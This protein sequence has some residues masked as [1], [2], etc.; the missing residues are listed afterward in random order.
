M[1]IYNPKRHNLK[2][3]RPP[4][5]K[6]NLIATIISFSIALEM[7]V[8]KCI[9]VLLHLHCAES[10][11]KIWKGLKEE[12]KWEVRGNRD[13]AKRTLV[14]GPTAVFDFEIPTDIWKVEKIVLPVSGAIIIQENHPIVLNTFEEKCGRNFA[15]YMVQQKSYWR[16]WFSAESWETENEPHNVATPSIDRIPC[17]CDSIVIPGD[18]ILPIDLEL[19]DYLTVKEVIINGMNGNFKE[20]LESEL[21][22]L[23][24]E[25]SALTTVAE[26]IC[27][28]THCTCHSNE[29]FLKYMEV[30]CNHDEYYCPT[31]YCF[32][33]IKPIGHCCPICGAMIQLEDS[34][35]SHS[36][37]VFLNKEH[38]LDAIKE[39]IRLYKN[40]K[41]ADLIDMSINIF[42]NNSD[43]STILQI[44]IV[45]RGEYNEYSTEIVKHLYGEHLDEL[46]ILQT[47]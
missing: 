44:T 15:N 42:P 19:I 36:R 45:D 12:G 6:W 24:F 14:F 17:E 25:D 37:S 29:R 33:P 43:V 38:I 5:N 11:T 35:E 31:P 8:L 23:M 40:G 30:V 4:F 3:I 21:G 47:F 34:C 22:Q 2:N 9:F 1:I 18:S 26:S 20:L 39:T 32:N 16:P 46:G 28:Q 13:C 41:Y 27:P 10:V 7:L